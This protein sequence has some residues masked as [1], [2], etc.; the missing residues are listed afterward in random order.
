[1]QLEGACPPRKSGLQLATTTAPRGYLI[2]SPSLLSFAV[3]AVRKG[4]APRLIGRTFEQ[5]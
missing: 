5:S 3:S 4:E 2:S 1:M